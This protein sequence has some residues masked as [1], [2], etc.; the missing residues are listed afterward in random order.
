MCMWKLILA[1]CA[2]E[3]NDQANMKNAS[4]N[5]VSN[6]CAECAWEMDVLI[7]AECMCKNDF[8]RYFKNLFMLCYGI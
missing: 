8:A 1:K 7:F 5:A 2:W 4:G 6:S 3:K